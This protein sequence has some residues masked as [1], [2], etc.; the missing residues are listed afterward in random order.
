MT[1]EKLKE[2]REALEALPPP[3][4]KP[5]EPMAPEKGDC[6]NSGCYPCV[7]DIYSDQLDKYNEDMDTWKEQEE[8]RRDLEEKLRQAEMVASEAEKGAEGLYPDE[9]RAPEVSISSEATAG[10]SAQEGEKGNEGEILGHGDAL[11]MGSVSKVPGSGGE[12]QGGNSSC[13]SSETLREESDSEDPALHEEGDL[14]SL[15]QV[16]APSVF[17]ASPLSTEEQGHTGS[18][19]LGVTRG[20]MQRHL[21]ETA[22]N[23]SEG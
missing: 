21:G 23:H 6:C 15:R 1:E 4:R 13:L 2:L 19:S 8:R 14:S 12:A 20:I 3:K 11:Q 17:V 18:F 9:L 7:Y 10:A 16:P 22:R 5:V